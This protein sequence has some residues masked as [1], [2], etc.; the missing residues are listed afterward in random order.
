MTL[1]GCVLHNKPKSIYIGSQL[2]CTECYWQIERAKQTRAKLKV[3][4]DDKRQGDDLHADV[5]GDCDAG[6]TA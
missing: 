4:T 3:L 5:S 6:D 1:F 2:V